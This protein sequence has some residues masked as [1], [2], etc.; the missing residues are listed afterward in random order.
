MSDS[1]PIQQYIWK[2]DIVLNWTMKMLYAIKVKLQKF[3]WLLRSY[4]VWPTPCIL[5][6]DIKGLLFICIEKVRFLAC[7]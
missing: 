2:S 4:F 3:R 7:A 1:S 6:E 5:S